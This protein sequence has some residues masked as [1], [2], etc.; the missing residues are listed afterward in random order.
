VW[1]ATTGNDEGVELGFGAYLYTAAV[2]VSA[3]GV[4]RVWIQRS[5]AQKRAY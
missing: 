1:F 4:V 3:V 2:I 5:Q